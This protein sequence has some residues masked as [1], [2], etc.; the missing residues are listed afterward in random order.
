MECVILLFVTICQAGSATVSVYSFDTDSYECRFLT[1][2]LGEAYPG[3]MDN[4]MIN[5]LSNPLTLFASMDCKYWPWLKSN[6]HLPL[7]GPL[8]L[9]G[10]FQSIDA[11]QA[12]LLTFELLNP[13][14]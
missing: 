10:E 8:Q 6:L 9:S 1:L 7:K 5:L 13:F 12:K 11:N 2:G 4:V 3:T 14:W